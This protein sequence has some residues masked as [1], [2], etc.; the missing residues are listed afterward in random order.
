MLPCFWGGGSFLGMPNY[1]IMYLLLR[2]SPYFHYNTT[3]YVGVTGKS[4]LSE[5]FLRL[6]W[7]V[8]TMANR[9]YSKRI[10][11][12]TMIH[13]YH[14]AMQ[15]TTNAMNTLHWFEHG[16]TSLRELELQSHS[17][18]YIIWMRTYYT[19]VGRQWP[20]RITYVRDGSSHNSLQFYVLM[21]T[22]DRQEWLQNS[23]RTILYRECT[24]TRRMFNR[25]NY[26]LTS[27]SVQYTS[28]NS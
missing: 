23:N 12:D 19:G 18:L 27:R 16:F 28:T 5:A 17:N 9:L 3:T 6:I 10:H 24:R 15:H 1:S 11:H 4:Q 8:V 13:D 25:G 2:S 21:Y 20:F 22:F 14:S 26:C 7:R